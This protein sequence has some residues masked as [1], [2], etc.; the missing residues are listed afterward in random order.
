MLSRHRN[1]KAAK[2]FFKKILIN[3]HVKMQ[4]AINVDKNP[5]FPPACAELQKEG[6]LM[7]STKR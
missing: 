6:D 2:R 3:A 7:V 1:K 5:A 4:Q